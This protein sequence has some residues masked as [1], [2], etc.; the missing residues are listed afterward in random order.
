MVA[1]GSGGHGQRVCVDEVLAPE[2]DER[3]EQGKDREP[4]STQK[5]SAKPEVSAS[6]GAVP[7]ASRFSVWPHRLDR[8]PENDQDR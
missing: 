8:C 1:G 5:A 2:R 3:R 7:P 6:E 4:D